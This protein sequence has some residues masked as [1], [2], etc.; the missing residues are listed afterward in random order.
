MSGR[1]RGSSQSSRA[2]GLGRGRVVPISEHTPSP[3]LSTSTPGTSQVTPTIPPPAAPSPLRLAT[4]SQ[5]ANPSMHL[6]PP[7][8]PR[9]LK[10]FPSPA[11]VRRAYAQRAEDK[12]T[13]RFRLMFRSE[14]STNGRR[15][16][17]GSNNRKTRFRRPTT[18]ER[19]GATSRSC[20]MSECQQGEPGFLEGQLLA[21]RGFYEDSQDW[22]GGFFVT[23]L[24]TSGYGGSSASIANT[25]TCPAASEAEVVDLREQVQNLENQ[26]QVLQ[27]HI[28]EVRCLKDTLSQKDAWAEEYLLRGASMAH[29]G[30]ASVDGSLL[31]PVTP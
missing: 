19:G 2:H 7:P 5:Q 26:G 24:H 30:D 17:R 13:P 21:H 16:L 20:G 22:T 31:Q 25:Q 9:K 27:Q 18:T 23:C 10:R 14:G 3:F 11:M 6:D 4:D 15:S 8:P 29:G 1:I 12:I 28:Y